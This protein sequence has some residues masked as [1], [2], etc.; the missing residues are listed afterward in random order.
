MPQQRPKIERITFDEGRGSF[1]LAA[2]SG[3]LRAKVE[4][5]SQVLAPQA[6]VIFGTEI[7]HRGDTRGGQWI[8]PPANLIIIDPHQNAEPQAAID[9]AVATAIHECAHSAFTPLA[10]EQYEVTYREQVSEEDWPLYDVLINVLEDERIET[11]VVNRRPEWR[12]ELR[13]R[14]DRKLA[15]FGAQIREE[16]VF[17]EYSPFSLQAAAKWDYFNNRATDQRA[18]P[19]ARPRSHRCVQMVAIREP[20]NPVKLT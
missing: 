13:K 6:K 8:G 18:R 20:P 16:R 12:P 19:Y 11:I 9:L 1:L 4:R 17:Q 5:I 10:Q 14:W 7:S 15:E 3:E 2:A